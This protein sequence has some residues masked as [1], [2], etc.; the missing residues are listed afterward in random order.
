M[1]TPKNRKSISSKRP[2]LCR[3][4]ILCSV[5]THPQRDEI[6][7]EFLSWGSPAKIA[8]EYGLANRA[9]IYRHAHALNLYQKRTKNLC[10]A[11]ERIIEKVDNVPVN[12]PT[13]VIHAV[14]ALEKMRAQGKFK[15]AD[16]ESSRTEPFDCMTLEEYEVYAQSGV[17]P[18][19]YK[20]PKE[21]SGSTSSEGGENA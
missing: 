12:N 16:D 2:N 5:C 15:A 19:W 21:P 9:A 20:N 1:A 10:G 7:R 14:M 13:V 18:I 11:L 4:K 6:E 17:L 8:S 3:H